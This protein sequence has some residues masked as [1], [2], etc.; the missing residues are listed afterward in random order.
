M[1]KEVLGFDS[2]YWLPDFDLVQFLEYFEQ[3]LKEGQL[4][5]LLLFLNRSIAK[6]CLKLNK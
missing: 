5:G 6:Q 4:N 2:K 3:Y 1:S